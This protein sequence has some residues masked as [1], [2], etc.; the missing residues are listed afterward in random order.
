MKA[1]EG[2]VDLLNRY[3][4]IELTAINQY[5]L[6]SEMCASWGFTRLHD[7]FRSLS[8]EEMQD[9][10]EL[11]AHILYLEGLPNLQR[12]NQVRVGQ[13]VPETL[14]SGL[15]AERGAVDFLRDGIEHC[16]RVGDYTT[17]AMFEQMM[18]DEEHHVD[19]FE[20]Q[21]DALRQVGLQNYLSQQLHNGAPSTD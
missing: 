5:F 17:R 3:L 15:E 11:I 6:A 9:A 4:T 8:M 14:E 12:L 1:R 18:R 2:I 7:R 13:D 16:A 21:L 19:W 20:T 10:Q